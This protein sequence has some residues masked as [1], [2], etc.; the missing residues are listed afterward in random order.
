MFRIRSSCRRNTARRVRLR[1]ITTVLVSHSAFFPLSLRSARPELPVSLSRGVNGSWGVERPVWGITA[2]RWAHR[3][4]DCRLGSST[5]SQNTLEDVR[6]CR[7][8]LHWRTSS[9]QTSDRTSSFPKK[10]KSKEEESKKPPAWLVLEEQQPQLCEKWPILPTG[11]R[12]SRPFPRSSQASQTLLSS[13]IFLFIFYKSLEF[14]KRPLVHPC[15]INAHLNLKTSFQQSSPLL[16]RSEVSLECAGFE[17]NSHTAQSPLLELV[18]RGAS[19][20]SPSR[21]QP[22]EAPA[23]PHAF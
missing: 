20:C 9:A 2:G 3:Q 14:F 22:A 8:Q 11:A 10:G 6:Q 4:P 18:S 23:F 15:P 16:P 19:H 5:L 17:R 12:I 21:V 1:F 7:H 13:F